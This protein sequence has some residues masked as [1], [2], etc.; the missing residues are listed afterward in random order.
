MPEDSLIRVRLTPRAARQGITGWR[1]DVLLVRVTAP[2]VEGRANE[3]LLRLL[4]QALGLGRTQVR[5]VSGTASRDKTV[6]VEG[7]S[8]AEVRARLGA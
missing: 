8:Q 3:A 4:A 7:L 6:R 5:L 2:P 1:E